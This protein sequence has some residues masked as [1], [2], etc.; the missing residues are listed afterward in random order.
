MHLTVTQVA[1]KTGLSRAA[2]YE[3]IRDNSLTAIK[4]ASGRWLIPKSAYDRLEAKGYR[5]N[6]PNSRPAT[7]I[8][9]AG[10]RDD[11]IPVVDSNQPGY[12]SPDDRLSILLAASQVK[13][14]GGNPINVLKE[15]AQNTPY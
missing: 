5:I 2:I 11:L 8:Y 3:K 1:E 14:S 6:A 4:D 13:A 15:L 9:I 10:S 12:L 7:N